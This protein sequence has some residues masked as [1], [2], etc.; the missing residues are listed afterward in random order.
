MKKWIVF[1][2]ML[3]ILSGCGSGGAKETS[4]STASETE[5]SSSEKKIELKSVDFEVE[6]TAYKVKIL[7]SW[8]VRQ[9]EDFSFSASNED[10]TEG[11][12]VSGFKKMD[13]DDFEVFKNAM[14]EQIVSTDDFEIKE[15]TIK[16]ELF[17]TSHY[18]GELYSFM[19][20]SDGVNIEIRFYLLEAEDEYILLNLIGLPSFFSKN[21][22][23]VTEML[24][25]FVAG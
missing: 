24:N 1:A 10:E 14:K 20:K 9:D 15:D 11:I 4:K 23:V 8:K 7:N 22:D 3:G 17:Q 13:I 21:S 25:S 18:K 16:E 2:V 19:G 5:V 12:M 6:E